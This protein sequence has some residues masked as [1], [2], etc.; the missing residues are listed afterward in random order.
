MRMTS[1]WLER[2]RIRLPCGRNGW[3]KWILMNPH[4]FLIT[5]IW[6]VLNVISAGPTEKSPG[7]EKTSRKDGCVVPWHVRICSK[8]ALRGTA[9]WQTQKVEQLYK[10]SSPCLDDHQFKKEEFES[11]GELSNIC[12][13]TVL[14]CL[15]LARNDR[16]DIL[17]SVNKLARAVTKWTQA[18]DRRLARLISHIHHTNDHRQYCQVGNTAQHLSPGFSPRL[19]FCWRLWGLQINLGRSFYVLGSRTFVP[20]SL[21]WNKRQYPTVQQNLKSFLWMLDCERMD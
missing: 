13:Q 20:I 4:H 19:R 17:W 14:K 18:Q 12:S 21:M 15:Y 16:P 11:V 10:V 3:K 7:W 9:G 2:N 1:K 8:K 6:N 5:C